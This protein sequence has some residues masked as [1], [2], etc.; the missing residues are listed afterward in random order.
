MFGI[1]ASLVSVVNISKKTCFCQKSP[2]L[3]KIKKIKLQRSKENPF[4]ALI[5]HPGIMAWAYMSLLH[6]ISSLTVCNVIT[7]WLKA[8][9]NKTNA[10]SVWKSHYYMKLTADCQ[11]SSWIHYHDSSRLSSMESYLF[12]K[13]SISLLEYI[14]FHQASPRCDVVSR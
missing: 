5:I 10:H 9:V 6:R 7:R 13:L 11:V 14:S 1:V 12:L 4:T 2:H 3:K 8:S